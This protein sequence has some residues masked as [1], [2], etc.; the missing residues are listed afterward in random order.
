MSLKG[1]IARL[2]KAT[3]GSRE[4]DVR[5][6]GFIEGWSDADIEYAVSVIEAVNVPPRSSSV[7]CALTLVPEGQYIELRRHSDGWYALVGP[8][9]TDPK[10]YAGSQKPAAIALA[11]AALKARA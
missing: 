4:L 9:S 2:E 10:K 11:L 3:E 1:I 5:I 6:H 7:D 8:H